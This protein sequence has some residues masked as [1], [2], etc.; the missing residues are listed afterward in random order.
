[1]NR[2]LKMIEYA[3]MLIF[4]I[5]LGLIAEIS[6]K[7]IMG[8]ELSAMP[9]KY[10]YY[11]FG[12]I[13][14]Y[15]TFYIASGNSGKHMPLRNNWHH[16]IISGT[17][18]LAILMAFALSLFYVSYP[19]LFGQHLKL[20]AILSNGE[21]L[22]AG[23]SF[24]DESLLVY[25]ALLAYSFFVYAY[26]WTCHQVPFNRFIIDRLTN[27][28]LLGGEKYSTFWPFDTERYALNNLE[29]KLDLGR[30]FVKCKDVRMTASYSI[31]IILKLSRE[32]AR[33]I[34]LDSIFSEARILCINLLGNTAK[35]LT[36]AEL[37][38][39]DLNWPNPWP[40]GNN[41]FISFA[42]R[43]NIIAPD[44]EPL[45]PFSS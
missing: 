16:K 20:K 13:G 29:Q 41:I 34:S 3:L 1:M 32:G 37:Q 14:F 7:I 17:G 26:I 30:F 45:K 8:L 6:A 42:K 19:I 2:T 44:Y 23:M 36:A 15:F 33:T 25:L 38:I 43:I 24:L 5:S 18:T 39:A 27:K 12:G 28:Y 35:I 10:P 11:I 22:S 4:C 40:C 21:F 9:D 31:K